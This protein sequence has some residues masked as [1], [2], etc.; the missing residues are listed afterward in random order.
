MVK[1][2]CKNN[3]QVLQV[4]KVSRCCDSL[5]NML[6][7]IHNAA[8]ILCIDFFFT[9]YMDSVIANYWC[10][11]NSFW[12]NTLR[13]FH[14]RFAVLIKLFG[15]QFYH[16]QQFE[17]MQELHALSNIW[18]KETFRFSLLN[19]GLKVIFPFHFNKASTLLGLWVKNHSMCNEFSSKISDTPIKKIHTLT[20]IQYCYNPGHEK[21]NIK[22]GTSKT[23]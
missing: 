13:N 9:F 6:L 10:L 18:F 21:F 22:A 3:E 15:G 5:S 11:L 4:W 17:I 8:T 2:C 23:K 1:L 19:L 16:Y 7:L 20:H 12:R 14:H